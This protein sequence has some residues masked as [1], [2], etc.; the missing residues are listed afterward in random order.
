MIT[1]VKFETNSRMYMQV[2]RHIL[3]TYTSQK[4]E[5]SYNFSLNAYKHL[6]ILHVYTLADHFSANKISRNVA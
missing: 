5:D 3:Q 4:S 2:K 1:L 6:I